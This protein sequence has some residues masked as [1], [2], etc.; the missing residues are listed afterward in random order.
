MCRPVAQHHTYWNTETERPTRRAPARMCCSSVPRV[1][2]AACWLSV[3]IPWGNPFSIPAVQAEVVADAAPIWG[4]LV[5]DAKVLKLPTK[6]L[7]RIP[8]GFVQFEF[9]DL[10]TFA[11]E[12]HPV[13]HR[14]VLNRALSF[15]RAGG[16]LRPLRQLTHKDLQTLYHEL[17]HAFMD[18]LT[19]GSRQSSAGE[20]HADSLINFA[21]EQQHCRYERILITPIPQRKGQTEERFLSEEESWELLNE[22]WAVFVGWAV[23]TQLE[24]ARTTKQPTDIAAGTHN[25][26][27]RLRKADREGELSGYYEPRDPGEKAIAQK[28]FAAP[29]FRISATEVGR[30][31]RDVLQSSPDRIA[32]SVQMLEKDRVEMPSNLCEPSGS[33]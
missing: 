18:Y 28:R 8:A 33:P 26:I 17:F 31:M 9:D 4:K 23:W 21:R 29:A 24:L 27:E 22:T 1:L 15:N 5:A 6:F 7:E 2:V 20:N 32:R 25:W 13:E 16:T 12:Y 14:M 11:A 19:A 30:L 3:I 10:R